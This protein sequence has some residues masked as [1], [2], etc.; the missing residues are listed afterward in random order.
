MPTTP[1]GTAYSTY[2]ATVDGAD[3]VRWA[4]ADSKISTA[5]IPVILYAHGAAGADNQF[6]TLA[7]W[8]GLR[9]WLIDNGW[10]WIEGTGGGSQPWGNAASRTAY[11]N[12]YLHVAGIM[13]LGP[14]VVLGRSMGGLVGQW[15]YTQS[16]VIAPVAVGAILNS[17]VQNLAAA[18]ASGNWTTAMR[19]AYGATSTPEFNAASVGFD[20]LLFPATSWQGRNIIQLWGDA[21]TLV[22][23]A[24]HAI[25]MRTHYAG[26]PAID[27]FDIREGG[28]HSATNG[29]YLE[30]DAMALFLTQVVG[31]EPP[32][33]AEP[34][35]VYRVRERYFIDSNMRKHRIRERI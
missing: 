22:P 4:V 16:L 9:N 24:D 5:N 18:Y 27:S 13:D 14:V 29:S 34:K 33:P 8:A 26:K 30:V 20:P 35:M 2:S 10:A 17:G 1:A 3:T 6:Q 11:E 28:D 12:A 19:A 21:D 32:E 31:S 15:L 7:A 25:A 23:P